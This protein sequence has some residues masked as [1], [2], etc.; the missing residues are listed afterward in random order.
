[1]FKVKASVLGIQ[2]ENL[3]QILI[4][5]SYPVKNYKKDHI[6]WCAFKRFG[7]YVI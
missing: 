4:F 6:K 3:K 7:A 5:C 2:A 1:M